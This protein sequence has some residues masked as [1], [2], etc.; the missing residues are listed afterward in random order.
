[1]EMHSR[2]WE[3]YVV[4]YLVGTVAG[5]VIVVLANAQKGSVYSGR[6]DEVVDLGQ[7]PFLGVSLLAALGFGFCY[8]ASL[9]ILALHAAR[10][11]LRWR[12]LR[13]R[14]ASHLGILAVSIPAVTWAASKIV[15]FPAA[16]VFGTV[17]GTEVGLIVVATFGRFGLIEH[18]YREIATSRARAM[19]KKESPPTAGSEYITS[20]RHLRE[21]GN[22][23]GILILEGVLAYC[24]LKV[25]VLQYAFP[26]IMAW[27]LPA[28][29]A[30]LIATALE[31]RL[32]SQAL[33]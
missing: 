9:P 10:A 13:S 31:S 24:L 14:W 21:H 5:A 4:R 8:V 25:S 7:H 30:W 17:V 15:S 20:Y 28:G 18:F 32:I 11:H 1:M 2:W 3:Y 12:T 26:L 16:L 27:V 6:L 23:A 33:D 29:A 22:A 19:P